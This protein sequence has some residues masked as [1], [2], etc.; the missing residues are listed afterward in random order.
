MSEIILLKDRLIQAQNELLQMDIKM[1]ALI[2][3]NERL[4]G[5]PKHNQPTR[6]PTCLFC[7]N[8]AET[9]NP[10]H[11]QTCYKHRRTVIIGNE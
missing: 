10:L 6:T 5:V 11:Q 7:N 1:S 2:K 3:E 8:V 9:F 4:R